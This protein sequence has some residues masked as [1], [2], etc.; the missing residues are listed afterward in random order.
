MGIDLST[1]TPAFDGGAQTGIPLWDFEDND[2]PNIKSASY[3]Y[4]DGQYQELT[5]ETKIADVFNIS[6]S[7]FDWCNELV[8][9]LEVEDLTFESMNSKWSNVWFSN[10]DLS[11][12]K[13]GEKTF[14]FTVTD[15]FGNIGTYEITANLKQA[16]TSMWLSITGF[17][18]IG[19]YLVLKRRKK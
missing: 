17:L 6:L 19:S 5:E 2:V 7:T 12:L 8:G 10:I 4:L 1:L 9:E 11:E 3:K 15:Q 18:V 16:S 13:N 14:L